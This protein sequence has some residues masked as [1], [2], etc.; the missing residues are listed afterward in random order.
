[1]FRFT[2]TARDGDGDVA[3]SG[4][5][6]KII[7]DSPVRG[8][9]ERSRAEDEAVNGG[10]DEDDGLSRVADGSLN[11]RWGADDA[12]SD[13]G[14]NGD[15]SVGFANSSVGV[16]GAYGETL[17]SLGQPVNFTVING[18]LVGYT[19]EAAPTD[20][21]VETVSEN[22]VFYVTL[23]DDAQ[24]SFEFRLVQPLD[25]ATNEG[26][27]V[28]ND[29][30]LTF[31]YTATDSDGDTITGSFTVDVQDDVA[32]IG[33]PFAGGVVEE[34]QRQVAGDGNEDRGGDG[35]R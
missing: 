30:S 14:G 20:F 7:D 17:T 24:G 11:I 16:V 26:T 6:V 21:S 35:D 3:E 19:G 27:G 28:E 12:D 22:V 29:L 1:S 31:N 33:T 32:S 15:R 9:E 4:F 13:L 2:F 8:E 23:S 5:T 10:N 18:I 34:E 25:H